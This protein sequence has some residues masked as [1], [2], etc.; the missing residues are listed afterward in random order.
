M[1]N[2]LRKI[3]YFLKF[4]IY[5]SP[6]VAALYLLL[7]LVQV[8]NVSLFKKLNILFGLIPG[9]IDKIIPITADLNGM[10]V[11]MGYVYFATVMILSTIAAIKLENHIIDNYNEK[12][13]KISEGNLRRRKLNQKQKMGEKKYATEPS[14]Y[15][16]GLLE[17][18]FEFLNDINQP[19]EQLEKLKKEYTKLLVNKLK[20]KYS[21]VQF[22]ISSKV[23]IVSKEFSLF[24]PILCDIIRFFGV[25]QEVN[26][27]KYISSTLLLSFDSGDAASN[28]KYIYRFLSKINDLDHKNKV[29]VLEKFSK[30]YKY[31]LTKQFISVPLGLQKIE[32]DNSEFDIDLYYLE[33]Q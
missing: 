8:F 1:D 17:L 2:K 5:T 10:D 19:Y 7:W 14:S 25:F 20:E 12:E 32:I 18:K 11:T 13:Q 33:N 15:F 3:V 16:F 31:V 30:K 22:V 26:N 9:F 23:F 24:D 28:P 27:E 29:I 21:D 4:W 6:A